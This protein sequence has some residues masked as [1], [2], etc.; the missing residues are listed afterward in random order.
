MRFRIGKPIISNAKPK[1]KIP[2]KYNEYLEIKNK[3]VLG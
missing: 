1:I 3:T 2:T